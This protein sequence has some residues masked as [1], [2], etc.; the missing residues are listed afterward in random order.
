[1]G[2]DGDRLGR[3]NSETRAEERRV[4]HTEGVEVAS[5]LVTETILTFVTVT[6]VIAGAAGLALDGAD[7]WSEGSTHGVGL[8]DVHLVTAGSVRTGTG[9][10]VGGGWCPAF[11]VSLC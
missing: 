7:V 10:R 8:P 2:N 11:D 3:V 1:M 9:V 6:T 4:A 5:V